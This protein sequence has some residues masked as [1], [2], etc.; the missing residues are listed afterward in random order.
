MIVAKISS[1]WN[2]SSSFS[3][4]L[5]F[6]SNWS[7]SISPHLSTRLESGTARLRH[8]FGFRR[9]IF[10]CFHHP[11]S[12]SPNN[13]RHRRSRQILYL[14]TC[15]FDIGKQC[16]LYLDARVTNKSHSRVCL[17]RCRHYYLERPNFN[18]T[19]QTPQHHVLSLIVDVSKSRDTDVGGPPIADHS[20]R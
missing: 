9:P 1:V 12:S 6:I 11:S 15:H 19:D 10:P 8:L 18:P 17:P 20:L 16:D 2:Y 3:F 13:L 14:I 4:V 7:L 5:V